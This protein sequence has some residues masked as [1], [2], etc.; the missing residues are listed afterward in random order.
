MT[1]PEPPARSSVLPALL[2]RSVSPVLLALAG[3]LL[4]GWVF[5]LVLE[6]AIVRRTEASAFALLSRVGPDVE[7]VLAAGQDP[8]PAVEA[9]GR[10]LSLRATLIGADGRV[11]GDSAVERGRVASLENHAHR[12]E[13]EEAR[14]NGTGVN[15]RYSSTVGERLVYSAARLRGGEVLRFVFREKELDLWEAP[16]RRLTLALSALAGLLVAALVVRSRSR[17]AAELGFVRDGVASAARGERPANPGAVSEE[18]AVVMSALGDLA[19]L[20]AERDAGWRRKAAVCRTV[21]EEVPVGLLVVD[22]RLSLLEVNSEAVRLLG[23]EPAAVRAGEH[24]LELVREKPLA[25][26]L[27]TALAGGPRSARLTLPSERGGR[28]LDV[29]VAR[30]DGNGRPGD[31]AAVAILTET[32]RP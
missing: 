13:V 15:R 30:L 1:M 22:A 28:A 16:F 29:M 3:G 19:D 25:D 4:A 17:H 6:R 31:A 9:L 11:L 24:V 14:R 10:Q 18:T 32:G 5:N 20:A 23:A 8:Q 26:L 27:E 2:R 7:A 21:F 12:P